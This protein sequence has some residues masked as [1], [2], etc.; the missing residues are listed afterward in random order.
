MIPSLHL[1]IPFADSPSSLVDNKY[2]L[3]NSTIGDTM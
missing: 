3:L 2:R 1:C